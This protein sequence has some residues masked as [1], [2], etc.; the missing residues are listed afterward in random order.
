MSH[1]TLLCHIQHTHIAKNE[2]RSLCFSPIVWSFGILSHLFAALKT[3]DTRIVTR[4]D[5]SIEKFT[6][7]VRRHKPTEL[8]LPP[9][10]LTLILQSEFPKSIIHECL[11]TVLCMGSIVSEP[12]RKKFSQ[13]FPEKDLIVLYGMTEVGVSKT[14]PGEYK[15]KLTV[16]SILFPNLTFKIIDE[17]GQRLDENKV[18]EIC[19]KSSISFL[20]RMFMVQYWK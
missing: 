12:L 17:N 3:N 14:A 15:D 1:A 18:G 19:V 9:M 4:D 5:F 8:V 20:V 16:G 2:A 7:I 6:E 11:K 13:L 10:N